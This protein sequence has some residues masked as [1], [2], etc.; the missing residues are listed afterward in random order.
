MHLRQN[1]TKPKLRNPWKMIKQ[2][3]DSKHARKVSH[4]CGSEHTKTM[5]WYTRESKHARMVQLQNTP[6][7]NYDG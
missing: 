6:K 1:G 3:R 5:A 4:Q 2:S 7:K